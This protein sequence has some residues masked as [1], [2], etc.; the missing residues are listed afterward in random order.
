MHVENKSMNQQPTFPALHAETC[1][2]YLG[3]N[4]ACN[5]NLP[6]F[7]TQIIAEAHRER[8]NHDTETTLTMLEKKRQAFAVNA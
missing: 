4:F 3:D 1:C 8:L 6:K 2:A 7:A 5:T